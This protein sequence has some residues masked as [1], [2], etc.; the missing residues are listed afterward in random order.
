MKWIKDNFDKVENSKLVA[1]DK[2][3]GIYREHY[4]RNN[5][6]PINPQ[7]FANIAAKFFSPENKQLTS[8][9]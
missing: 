3:Y 8:V 9:K 7:T 4:L 5:I 2:I 6:A 1:V